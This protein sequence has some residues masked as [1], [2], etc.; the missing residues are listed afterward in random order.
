[1]NRYHKSAVLQT[2]KIKEWALL[3]LDELG[4]KKTLG[5][6]GNNYYTIAGRRKVRSRK[7]KEER[8]VSDK[9]PLNERELAIQRG[10]QEL[11]NARFNC[12]NKIL[13]PQFNVTF[14]SQK[15]MK[16]GFAIFIRFE[17]KIIG[18]ILKRLIFF[19]AYFCEFKQVLG[20]S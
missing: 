5:Q 11:K 16:I 13:L 2:R 18:K 17:V 6:L 10:I 1:M 3:F 20:T 12:G 8:I 9:T 14:P 15:P 19:I 7:A 4:V